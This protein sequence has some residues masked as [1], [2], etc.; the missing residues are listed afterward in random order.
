MKK[1]LSILLLSSCATFAQEDFS[2]PKDSLEY[3]VF[4]ET[5]PFWR[6]EKNWK[7]SPFDVFSAVS[8]VGL[9]LET[10][11]K[12]GLSFQ[13]GAAFIPSFLQFTVGNSN[14]QFNWMNGYKVRFE[15]RYSAFRREGLYLSGELAFRHLIIS[16]VTPVGME[17]DGFGNFA[18]FIN[19][20]MIYHRFSSHA[21]IKMGFQK[22]ISNK[23][24]VD[25]FAGMS[26]RVNNVFTNSDGP[27]EGVPQFNWNRFDWTLINH[28]IYGYAMPIVG[29][30]LGI[31]S[32]AKADI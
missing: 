8:T 21:N 2:S 9:D 23:L 16:D 20:E 10:V 19:H 4:K 11:V 27:S 3:N 32:P 13:Y 26:F 30:R 18:Y 31:H 22:I 12:P 6:L 5:V 14:D 25:V 15:S 1:L 7:F 28:H 17:G 24:C 29:L